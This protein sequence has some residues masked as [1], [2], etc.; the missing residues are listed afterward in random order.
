MV[1]TALALTA[2][3]IMLV[4]VA[5]FGRLNLFSLVLVG[6]LPAA[7]GVYQMSSERGTG[8]AGASAYIGCLVAFA[9]GW[10]VM[11][12]IAW[13]AS[14]R[15]TEQP[16]S[17][18]PGL[19][20]NAV[21]IT[22]LVTA[23]LALYHLAR[24]GIPLFASDIEVSRFDFTSSGLFGIPGRMFL[25][26]T[27][28][29][30]AFATA[31]AQHRGAV[32]IRDRTWWVATLSLALTS[33]LGGYKSG[34]VAFVT[35]LI[36][37]GSIVAGREIRISTAIRKFWWMA[38]ATLL[39]AFAVAQR[40]VTYQVQAGGFLSQLASRLSVVGA[41]PKWYAV[42]RQFEVP[43]NGFWNDLTY[44]LIRYTGGD[45][46][47]RYSI[48]RAVSAAMIGAD[49][50]SDAWTT[51]VTVGAFPE[52]ILVLGVPLAVVSAALVG[53]G[54]ASL[55]VRAPQ[56]PARNVVMAVV[57]LGLSTWVSRGGLVYYIANYAAVTVILFGVYI[58][59][60]ALGSRIDVRSPERPGR[61]FR[62]EPMTGLK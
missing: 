27:S 46:S 6:S 37:M 24:A 38:G 15:V 60:A 31:S 34:A 58:A 40:Y 33:L 45:T 30:W 62:T 54:A 29:A 39:Y 51:P 44:Y 18:R 25:F 12:T 47:G 4:C 50:A 32:W 23:A 1:T 13:R 22:V 17:D 52:L 11:R 19:N 59:A 48:E 42:E 41:E 26:G 57:G 49:P 53:V 55:Y 16:A 3:A 2:V 35:T 7:V 5:A 8:V 10:A 36:V 20:D 21:L 61:A 9:A 14:P 43:A 56:G 28:V